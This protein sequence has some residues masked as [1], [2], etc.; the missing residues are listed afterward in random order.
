MTHKCL[1]KNSKLPP[2][3]KQSN[4]AVFSINHLYDLEIRK[5]S[6]PPLMNIRIGGL[7][8]DFCY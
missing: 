7:T 1:G 2:S 5:T 8:I 3:T 6:I 4:F